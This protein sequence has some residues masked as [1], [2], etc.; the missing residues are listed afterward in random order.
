M[1]KKQGQI[2]MLCMYMYNP[3][4]KF[5]GRNRR[6][7]ALQNFSESKIPNYIE[8]DTLKQIVERNKYEDIQPQYA[9]YI[10][11]ILRVPHNYY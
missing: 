4:L 5:F 7:K 11:K 10:D 3:Q 2:L 8:I 1:K 9:Q 6:E